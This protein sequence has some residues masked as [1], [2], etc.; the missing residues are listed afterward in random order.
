[1]KAATYVSADNLQL[2]D[3]PKPVIKNPTDAIVRVLKTTICGT[4]LHI[5]GGDVPAC[6]E[7]TIFRS[8]RDPG[9]SKKSAMRL[10]TSRWATR[11]LSLVSQLVTPAT[12]VNVVCLLTVK[13]VV[14]FWV[15]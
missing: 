11:S 15:T 3:Q 2:L 5:L 1:M 8:R 12:T 9:S 4:D 6:K 13:M 14:G 7:G 10:L